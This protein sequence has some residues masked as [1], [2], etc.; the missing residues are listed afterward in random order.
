LQ[1]LA[2]QVACLHTKETI[3]ETIMETILLRASRL[4]GLMLAGLLIESI[5][6]HVQ[7]FLAGD[8]PSCAAF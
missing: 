7:Q 6:A 2:L 1:A 4:A 8:D 3:M 5:R